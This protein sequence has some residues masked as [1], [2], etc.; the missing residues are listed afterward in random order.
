MESRV[1]GKR[2]RFEVWFDVSAAMLE[3]EEDDKG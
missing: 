3:L 2:R 1:D